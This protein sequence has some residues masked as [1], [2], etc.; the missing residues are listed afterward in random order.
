[1]PMPL[2]HSERVFRGKSQTFSKNKVQNIVYWYNVKFDMLKNY[3]KPLAITVYHYFMYIYIL[4][5]LS[6]NK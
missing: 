1:M 2:A 4:I 5:F 6:S 3:R